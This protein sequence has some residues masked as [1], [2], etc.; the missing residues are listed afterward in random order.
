MPTERPE[1]VPKKAAKAKDAKAK[2]KEAARADR[3]AAVR[4]Q[5]VQA[6]PD[7]Q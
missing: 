4:E 5:P 1:V 3:L 7:P 6:A 2:A